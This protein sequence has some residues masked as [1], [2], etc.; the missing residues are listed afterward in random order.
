MLRLQEIEHGSERRAKVV[1]RDIAELRAEGRLERQRIDQLPPK[2]R[3]VIRNEYACCRR[4]TW[5]CFILTKVWSGSC[6]LLLPMHLGILRH[7]L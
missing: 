4:H 1:A 2:V 7:R 5:L 3:T 6:L